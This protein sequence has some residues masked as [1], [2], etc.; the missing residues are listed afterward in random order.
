MREVHPAALKHG[1]P[2]GDIQHAMKHPMRVIPQDND[3]HIYLGP[4]RNAELLEVVTIS[5]PEG[6]EI[7]VHAMKMRPKYENLIPRE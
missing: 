2:E 7:A 4:G 1:V 3:T 5:G 6:S